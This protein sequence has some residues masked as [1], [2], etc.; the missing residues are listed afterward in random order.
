MGI[1][2]LKKRLARNELLILDGAMGTEL[3]RKGVKTQLPLWSASA[4]LSSP[5]LVREIHE[6]YI[7]AGADIITT[8]TFRTQ[9]RTLAKAGIAEKTRGLNFLAVKLAKG[10]V[11][12]S[13]NR[14]CLVAGGIAPLEDCYSPELSPAYVQAKKEHSENAKFLADAGA[15]FFLIETMNTLHEARAALEAC[16]STGKG[17]MVS[18]VCNDNGKLLNGEP[19]SESMHSL[20]NLKPLAFLV[21]CISVSTANRVAKILARESPIAWG[22]YAQGLGKP[23]DKLGWKFTRGNMKDYFS[24]A[25]KWR[26]E[27]AAIIGGCCGTNPETI[28]QLSGLKSGNSTVFKR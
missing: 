11:K 3:Q 24:A 19:L 7:A 2:L 5:A 22:I 21:N 17:A 25:K 1:S 14:N 6:S 8:N 23:D 27:G 10:A 26:K 20:M 15:D 4:L 16:R 9:K 28:S 18:F 13:G 12:N